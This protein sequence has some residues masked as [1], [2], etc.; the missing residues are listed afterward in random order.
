MTDTPRPFDLAKLDTEGIRRRRRGKLIRYSLPIVIVAVL[1]ALKLLSLSLVTHFSTSAY[2]DRN[3]AASSSRLGILTFVNVIEPYKVH[4]N[5]GTAQLRNGDYAAAERNLTDALKI[6]PPIDECM[7]RVNLTRTYIIQADKAVESKEYGAA[8]VLYDKVKS[9]V[10]ARDCGL[11]TAPATASEAAK[12]ADKKLQQNAQEA[13]DKQNE[14]KKT[15]NG[16]QAEKT[17]NTDTSP[18]S[19]EPTDAQQKELQDKQSENDK[20]TRA[21]R[22]SDRQSTDEYSTR[23]YKDKA[24]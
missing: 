14:A 17:D 20:A 10:E 1:C 15:Q 19:G 22:N 5:Q 18:D 13:S 11:K 9:I 16:D 6:V 2:N 3:Y 7:V 24:W 8:I 21:R 12:S 23:N 4:F